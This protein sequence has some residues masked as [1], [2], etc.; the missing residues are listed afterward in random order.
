MNNFSNLT[1]NISGLVATPRV[2][3]EVIKVHLISVWG[4]IFHFVIYLSIHIVLGIMKENEEKIVNN[5]KE[6]LDKLKF[7]RIAFKWWPMIYLA[8]ILLNY[9]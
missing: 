7:L 1:F 4:I 3:G 2:E 9:I 6:H 5:D 8:F